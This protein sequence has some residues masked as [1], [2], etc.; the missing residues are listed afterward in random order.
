M[1]TRQVRQCCS[2]AAAF[3]IVH[4]LGTVEQRSLRRRLQHLSERLRARL[5]IFSEPPTARSPLQPGFSE[6]AVRPY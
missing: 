4:P 5:R 6:S 3:H 2:R 1:N